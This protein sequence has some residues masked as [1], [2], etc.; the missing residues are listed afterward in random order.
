[1]Y[2]KSS[3]RSG[4]RFS[5]SWGNNTY[6]GNIRRCM[7]WYNC[8][9]NLWRWCEI[10]Y[11]VGGIGNSGRYWRLGSTVSY[12]QFRE[13]LSICM[14]VDSP[15]EI[16]AMLDNWF[17]AKLLERWTF[18]RI[19]AVETKKCVVNCMLEGKHLCLFIYL[20]W[21]NIGYINIYLENDLN[22]C[23]VRLYSNDLMFKTV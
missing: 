15:S 13:C 18:G 1:M 9:I 2:I 21:N 7:L 22:I 8:G 16:M 4:C 14:H 3:G 19:F 6:W 12:L 11:M 20:G 10:L 23:K 5:Q 17:I